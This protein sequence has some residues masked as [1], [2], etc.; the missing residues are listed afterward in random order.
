ML[1]K[2]TCKEALAEKHLQRSTCRE[3]LEEP[4]RA[5][6]HINLNQLEE[7][8]WSFWAKIMLNHSNGPLWALSQI[9]LS[10][11]KEPWWSF[12]AKIMLSHFNEPL[13]A[14]SQIKLSQLKEPWWFLSQLNWAN[15]LGTNKPFWAILGQC[16]VS[17][18]WL[19][20]ELMQIVSWYMCLIL[21]IGI[22]FKHVAKCRQAIQIVDEACC[23]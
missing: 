15:F 22:T 7:P 1:Q 5:L 9:K 18:L 16:C 14:L 4:S 2:D 23:M 12:W 20:A 17:Q 3:A 21:C 19:W 6:S 13:W 8:V 10:Q 11:L